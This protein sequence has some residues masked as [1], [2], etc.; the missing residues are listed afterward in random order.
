[1]GKELPE[2][3]LKI[4]AA[5]EEKLAMGYTEAKLALCFGTINGGENEDEG[6]YL[7]NVNGWGTT[8]VTELICYD[9]EADDSELKLT[10][11]RMGI[12]HF[13]G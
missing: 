4:V 11:S 7:A 13:I 5:I 3:N 2:G 9:G 1:M 8:P 12:K 6:Y 10:L